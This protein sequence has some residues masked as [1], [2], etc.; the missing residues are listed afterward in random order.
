MAQVMFN[1]NE[2]ATSLNAQ[3]YPY[4]RSCVGQLGQILSRAHVPAD[5]WAVHVCLSGYGFKEQ[6]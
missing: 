3:G 4:Q 6:K 1:M 5:E 2:Y